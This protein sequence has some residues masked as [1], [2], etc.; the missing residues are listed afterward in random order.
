MKELKKLCSACK[1]EKSHSCFVKNR[2]KADGLSFECKECKKTYQRNWY[3]RNRDRLIAKSAKRS[4]AV[5]QENA[6]RVWEYLLSHP[7]VDCFEGDPIVLE[8]DHVR[9]AKVASICQMVAE[10]YCWDT[11]FKEIDKCDVRCANCHRRKTAISR[12]FMRVGFSKTVTLD[13]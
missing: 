13:F 4:Q 2:S 7:C 10:G 6:K 3:L 11:I 8:F 1:E 12:D 9:G 5:R